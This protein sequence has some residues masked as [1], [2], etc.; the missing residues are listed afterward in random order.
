MKLVE[1]HSFSNADRERLRL[2][3]SVLCLL[4][5]VLFS[6]STIYYITNYGTMISAALIVEPRFSK[7]NVIFMVSDGFGPASEV[8]LCA[9]NSCS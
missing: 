7:R 4:S 3:G 6:A 8:F 2:L 1:I 9:Y 5:L